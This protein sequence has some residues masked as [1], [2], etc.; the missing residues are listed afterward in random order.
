MKNWFIGKILGFVGRKLDGYK[1]K[2]GGAGLILVGVAGIIAEIF[3]DQGL[4]KMG[5]ESSIGSIAAGITALGLAHKAV[6]TQAA[7]K[8]LQ[9]PVEQSPASKTPDATVTPDVVPPPK[10]W[11]GKIPGQFP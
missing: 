2:I 9:T 7:I 3:P 4:P 11:D 6:K 10:Q 8:E 1:S 5:L